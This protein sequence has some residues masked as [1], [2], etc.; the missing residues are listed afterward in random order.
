MRSFLA[1]REVRS[2]KARLEG[3]VIDADGHHVEFIP[4]VREFLVDL[5][6]PE[7]VRKFDDFMAPSALT[8]SGAARVFWPIPVQTLDR[9]TVI[10]PELLSCRLEELGID[11][12][13]L[14]PTFGLAALNVPDPELRAAMI[15][16]LNRYYAE[17]FGRY[18]E[19]LEPVAVIPTHNPQE[20]IDELDFAI[21]ELG[22]KAVVMNAVIPRS[23]RPDGHPEPWLDTIGYGSPFDYEPVWAK[24]QQE[25]VSL[26]FHGIGYGWGSRNS[27]TNYVYNHLGSFAAAQEAAC[28]SIFM[29]GVAQRFPSLPFAFLEG[30]VSWACQLLSDIHSHYDKRNRVAVQQFNPATLDV[31]AC[32]GLFREFARGRSRSL[33]ERFAE[34]QAQSKVADPLDVDAA[35]D[36]SDAGLTQASD[37]TD[38][39]SNRFYFGC[40]ADDP[41]NGL[42]FDQRMLPPETSLNAMFASDIGHWDVPD[43]RGV[44]VEAW[45]LVEHGQM[46]EDQFGQFVGGN[47]IKM[48]T[49]ANPMFFKGT[50][51]ENAVSAVAS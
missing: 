1:S 29:G 19:R 20:A 27:T 47:V 13:M 26:A 41:M 3:P 7:I 16:A 31:E 51:V 32:V 22:L 17:I 48:L 34:Y 11:Y 49:S 36:F 38:I 10:L 37:I 21:G 40:E 23:V 42:A 30:G 4:L 14:Y 43:L 5:A 44:L 6:S 50:A 8:H 15:R 12:A 2:I 18:R 35:D 39:F 24:C 33:V 28:R 46:T 25:G 45:E 9:M